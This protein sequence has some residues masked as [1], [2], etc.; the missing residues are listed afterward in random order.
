MRECDECEFAAV[1]NEAIFRE[2]TMDD[3]KVRKQE[4]ETY[5]VSDGNGHWCYITLMM[6]GTVLVASPSHQYYG[7]YY[8]PERHREEPDLLKFLAQCDQQYLCSKLFADRYKEF[9]YEKTM[10]ELKKGIIYAR[11]SGT[12]SAQEAR[13]YWDELSSVDIETPESIYNASSL[14]DV[15]ESFVYENSPSIKSFFNDI[16]QPFLGMLV[17]AE[18]RK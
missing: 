4:A 14:D 8:W 7:S 17:V 18:S 3:I 12:Y 10:S 11:R 15:Y 16:W 6:G 13:N 9:N 1:K 5:Y 2:M